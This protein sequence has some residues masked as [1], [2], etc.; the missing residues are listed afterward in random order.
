M[1]LTLEVK[2]MKIEYY[3]WSKGVLDEVLLMHKYNKIPTLDI[4]LTSKCSRASC[5]YCD[6]KPVVC[7]NGSFGEVS[8]EEIKKAV[9]EAKKNGLKFVY[10]CGLGE[11]LED[12]KFWNMIHL[13]KSNEICF[14]IF[15]NGI[16]ITDIN[17]AK[18]L[19]KHNV[20]IIL[21]MD[22]FNEK[23]FDAILGGV[24]ISSK[25][26]AARDYL[27]EAG[28]GGKTN[29]TDLAFSIVPTSMS[30]DG[31][32]QVVNFAKKH[33]IFASIGEL[34]QAGEVI[35]NNLN[36]KLSISIEKI[37][38]LKKVADYYIEGSYMR[39]ICPCILTGL[40]IDNFGN[41]IVDKDTG[42]NCKWFLLKDPR[43]I[44][45]GNIM[46]ESIFSLFKKAHLYRKECFEKNLDLIKTNCDLSYIFGGCGGNP[47]DILKLAIE[48][49]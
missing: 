7:N 44:K 37:K 22:T 12:K 39:P 46:D 28:Y 43:T 47:R 13:F 27:L 6:S 35:N 34:E 40:H 33:G 1:N 19:K 20:N 14:S 48:N 23:K 26:Y 10:S 45:L 16:F 21:K 25:I 36:E 11:P 9:L 2:I 17:V 15:S 30:I 4:D 3:P 38:E 5:I 29:I 8:F 32:P 24:G 42:L 49:I 41:C 31:I 18:E